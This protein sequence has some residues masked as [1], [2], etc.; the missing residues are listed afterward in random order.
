MISA[1][2]EDGYQHPLVK[3]DFGRVGLGVIPEGSDDPVAISEPIDY[4]YRSYELTSGILDVPYKIDR[5]TLE[6]GTLVLL[7]E[8]DEEGD[9]LPMLVES[10]RTSRS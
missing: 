2:P 5:D 9:T 4:D 3:A 8:P 10:E 6:Q 1:F 7:T